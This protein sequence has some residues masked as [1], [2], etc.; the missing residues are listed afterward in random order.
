M[1][2]SWRPFLPKYLRTPILISLLFGSAMI[3]LYISVLFSLQPVIP[4]FYSLA[5]ID[6]HLADKE[7]LIIFPIISFL[8]TMIHFGMIQLFKF[9]DTILLKIFTWMTV[10][11]QILLAISMIRIYLL[12]T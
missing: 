7:L 5:R 1:N 11:I 2:I 12:V 4:L 10:F 8:I 3:V 6:Q 9:L